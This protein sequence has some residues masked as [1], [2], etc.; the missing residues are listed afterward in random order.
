MR[1]TIYARIRPAGPVFFDREL[2]A[3]LADVEGGAWHLRE[4][5]AYDPVAVCKAEGEL[6]PDPGRLDRD[7]S[8]EVKQEGEPTS[9]SAREVLDGGAGDAVTILWQRE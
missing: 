6:V 5:N 9:L 4:W 3:I 2:S 8:L 7:F 1:F